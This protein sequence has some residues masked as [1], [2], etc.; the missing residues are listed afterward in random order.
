MG[1][2]F[3]FAPEGRENNGDGGGMRGR[4]KKAPPCINDFWAFSL[5]LSIDFGAHWAILMPSD[6][7]KLV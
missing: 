7:F 1:I 5:I 2:V 3:V 4:A 6:V